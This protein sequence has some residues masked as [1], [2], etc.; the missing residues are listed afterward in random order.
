MPTWGWIL[1][2][3]AAALVAGAAVWLVASR[4]RT[5]HLQEQ[6]GPEYNRV[7]SASESRREAEGELSRR[8]E[9]WEK[10][11]VQPLPEESR[12]RYAEEWKVVQAEFV[13]EPG[14]AVARADSL[15][16]QVMAERGYPVEKFDQRVADLSVDHP[17]VVENY[18][19]GHRLATKNQ[20]N[21]SDT[22]DLRQ[23]MRH[24][25][26]LFEELVEGDSPQRVTS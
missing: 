22:E 2:V 6:F 20:G 15:L 11:D 8:E 24:Y 23:A 1:I 21:G 9:R 16:Q 7:T 17:K 13:D 19:E 14:R 5:A 18:R 12:A 26:A 4:K 10:I 25:R 3:I